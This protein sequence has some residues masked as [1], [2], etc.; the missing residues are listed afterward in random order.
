MNAHLVQSR[1]FC[2]LAEKEYMLR[3][4]KRKELHK[5]SKEQVTVESKWEESLRSQ[6]DDVTIMILQ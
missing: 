4:I 5:E 2:L 1:C 3:L 6:Y